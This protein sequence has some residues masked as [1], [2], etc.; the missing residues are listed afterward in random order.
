MARKVLLRGEV[1]LFPKEVSYPP[2]LKWAGGKRWL[3]PFIKDIYSECGPRRLVEPFVG[4]MAVSLH[5]LPKTALL[6]DANVHLIN[7]YKHLQR[8][9]E[10]E[11][12]LVND[13]EHY[14]S[15]RERFNQLIR[16][17]E[18]ESKEAAELFYYLNRTGFNG[19]C[20]FNK[21]GEF[22]V[23]FGK[24]KHISYKK[25]FREYAEILADYVF[26]SGDFRD[27][28]LDPEDFVYADPP[29]D[30]E[31]TEYSA[32]G[33]SFEDQIDLAALLSKHG[34]PVLI[35]NQATSRIV[36]LYGDYGFDTIFL[37]APRRIS[38]NGDRS[39]ALEVLAARG[40]DG[41]LLR[42]V[43]SSHDVFVR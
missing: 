3:A 22:N 42:Q 10:L 4:G 18:A 28:P 16:T 6:N 25:D 21:K 29:Y 17:G 37:S 15:A 41:K 11:I 12:P 14:Y 32:G 34:G 1:A 24:Y 31:F 30:V 27:L 35:S 13:K 23:P 38:S 26:T 36:E 19:L 9:L 43:F 5:I 39:P 20:R 8:G 2:P 40:I 7:F 33:F